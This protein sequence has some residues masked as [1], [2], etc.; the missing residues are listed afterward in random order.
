MA[1]NVGAKSAKL[2][3]SLSFVTPAFRNGLE[4]RN[5]DLR[6]LNEILSLYIISAS[7]YER[8]A[9]VTGVS[10]GPSVCLHM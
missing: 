6:V 3:E 9:H 5:Y 8:S 1:T 2:V 4:N 7:L 10:P